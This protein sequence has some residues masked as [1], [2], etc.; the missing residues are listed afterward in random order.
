[1]RQ[2]LLIIVALFILI[3]LLIGLNAASY[4]Q[5]EKL[6][7]SEM[8]PNRST[9]NGGA[10]GTRAFFDLLNET[11]RRPIRWIEPP[12]ELDGPDSPST[13]VV[14]GRLRQPFTEKEI[15]DLLRWVAQGRRLVIIDRE[16]AEGLVKSS[17]NYLVRLEPSQ[18]PF[19]DTD[20]YDQS[21]MTVSTKAAM[22]KQPT[23][24][25]IGVNS[26]QPS[27]FSASVEF[28]RADN[29]DS[30]AGLARIA[31]PRDLGTESIEE[32]QEFKVEP[33]PTP[34]VRIKRSG[35]FTVPAQPSPT[36]TPESYLDA[37]VAYDSGP[38]GSE[39]FDPYS[40]D[41]ALTAPVVHFANDRKNIVV[42][43]PYG[44]GQIVFVSDPYVVSNTGLSVADNTAFALN[45][46][47]LSGTIAFDEYHQGYGSNR[48]RFFEFF[49]GTPVIAIFLQIILI[50]GLV[51]YSRSRRFAR[52]VPEREPNRLS[53]LEY[54]SAMAELQQRTKGFD[55][56]VEN[57]YG[58]FRRRVTRLV[59]V[60]NRSTG[61][62]ELARLIA[63]RVG[64]ESAAELEDLMRRC[65]D[66]VHGD[67][68]NR[69]EVLHLVT[70]LRGLET[71]L[72]LQRRM[73]P[74]EN[75]SESGD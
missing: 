16:P 29:A 62:R 34:G 42:D 3:A 70:R 68:T 73:R 10:T 1:M 74:R 36:A 26:V 6:P 72:G 21:Q 49:A 20:A 75:Q 35:E 14:I 59:G 50:S 47:G 65:E 22:P 18:Y 55:L 11:G 13:F 58:E 51:L 28:R 23:V 46:A 45:L 30:E 57:I 12:S 25:T 9:F 41:L 24:F 52:A 64:D 66:I 53:K 67:R 37:P 60:D 44:S 2:R 4:T 43:V 31:P 32:E 56:A 7:D 54:V 27:R 15:E 69:K 8:L 5:K 48:N 19:F 17:G 39:D 40:V 61:R 63:E 38:T 33:S 71:K